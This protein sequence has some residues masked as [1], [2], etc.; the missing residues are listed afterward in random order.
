MGSAPSVPTTL[1]ECINEEGSICFEKF[2]QYRKRRAEID[3]DDNNS[4]DNN[5]DN[6]D[7]NIRNRRIRSCKKKS[8]ELLLSDGTIYNPTPRTSDW[9]IL[10]VANPAIDRD[11]FHQ[12]FRNKFRL[13]YDLFLSLLHEISEDE[14]FRQWTN[15]IDCTGIQSTPI[16]L[17][18]LGTLR[19]LGRDCKIDCI[20]FQIKVSFA[21]MQT[22]F[23][24]FCAFGA[25]I[26]FEKHV[27]HPTTTRELYDNMKVYAEMGLHGAVGSMDATHVMSIRIPSSLYQVHKSFKHHHPARSY[28]ITVNHKGRILHSTRGFPARMNDQS[29]VRYDSFYLKILKGEIGNDVEFF[30]Y[31]ADAS[32]GKVLLQKYKGVWII[33][34]N[35]YLAESITVPPSKITRFKDDQNFSEWLESVRKDVERTFGILKGRFEIL[36]TQCRYHKIERMDNVWM[37][38]CSLHNMI[39]DFDNIDNV[40]EE[41]DSIDFFHSLQLKQ[42]EA[43]NGLFVDLDPNA[44]FVPNDTTYPNG[45]DVIPLNKLQ[46]DVFKSRLIKHYAICKQLGQSIWK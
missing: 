15:K 12:D 42:Q 29:I 37:T 19:L 5:N 38:C 36:R 26:L 25:T 16:E 41:E 32:T 33:V 4:D 11:D 13:P 18:L 31:Y 34:D 9:Y 27:K 40:I 21:T 28:N 17:L 10:Y 1:S 8:N 3:N 14:T 20:A 24:K 30:L 35:G 23:H 22:F 44:A 43:I 7:D 6:N 45:C 46:L 2:F 39:H